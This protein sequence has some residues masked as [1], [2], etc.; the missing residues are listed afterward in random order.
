MIAGEMIYEILTMPLARNSVETGSLA[1]LATMVKEILLWI[2][3]RCWSS[4]TAFC[5]FY[6]V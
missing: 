4:K 2:V 5:Q 6:L 1:A 3:E